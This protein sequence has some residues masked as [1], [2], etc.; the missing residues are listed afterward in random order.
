M[1][2]DVT[3]DTDILYFTLQQ[4]VFECKNKNN[5]ATYNTVV[6]HKKSL[7]GCRVDLSGSGYGPK[8]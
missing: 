7:G 5:L 2:K 4:A 3:F 8:V 6:C 1:P